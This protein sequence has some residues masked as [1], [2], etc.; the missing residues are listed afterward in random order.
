M[1]T[2]MI[3][4]VEDQPETELVDWQVMLLANGDRH[5]VGYCREHREGRASTAVQRFDW[6]NMRAVTSSGRV[7]QLLAPPGHDGDAAYV[8]RRWAR[9]N[10]V[11]SGDDVSKQ[12]WLQH[13]EVALGQNQ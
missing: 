12:V 8:W 11:S 4:S 6:R 3:Q 7:Y 1:T 5:L 9:I 2:W 13:L 10:R